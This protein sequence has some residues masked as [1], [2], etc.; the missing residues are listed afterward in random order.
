MRHFKQF[1]SKLETSDNLPLIEAI[2]LGFYTIFE[3]YTENAEL[4]PDSR[5]KVYHGTTEKGVKEL[6]KG[7]VI[8]AT[9]VIP[10]LY[11]QGINAKGEH[12]ERGLYVT[13]DIE[14]AKRFGNTII[15]FTALGKNLYPPSTFLGLDRDGRQHE[16]M[17]KLVNEEY[18]NSFRPYTSYSMN[19]DSEPQAVFIGTLPV[20]SIDNIYQKTKGDGPL[21]E[22]PVSVFFNADKDVVSD[23]TWE[24]D[25]ILN[26]LSQR[27]NKDIDRIIKILVK[28]KD[29]FNKL[30]VVKDMPRK[31]QL[32]L[33]TYIRNL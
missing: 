26:Y 30:G 21:K 19:E 11:N 4:Q 29:N 2:S 1:L 17:L 32:R 33:K 6:F 25:D 14:V 18:P 27:F 12:T 10:R 8:D 20:S 23:V 9:K 15:E 22:I 24:I 13:D 28:N 31:L 5:I 3:G 7:G 16:G